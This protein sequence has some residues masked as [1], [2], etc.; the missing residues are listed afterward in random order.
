MPNTQSFL[1]HCKNF[2]LEAPWWVLIAWFRVLNSQF[3]ISFGNVLWTQFFFNSKE[4][5]H[6]RQMW[7]CSAHVPYCS[8]WYSPRWDVHKCY[9]IFH[10]FCQVCMLE[11]RNVRVNWFSCKWTQYK[12]STEIINWSV[13][14]ELDNGLSALLQEL[15]NYISTNFFYC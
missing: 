8:N 14:S 5:V 11:G 15:L 10:E 3:T 1:F 7:C 9:K 2:C 4:C 12:N 6:L 13:N